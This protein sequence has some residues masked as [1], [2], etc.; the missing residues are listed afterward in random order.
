MAREEGGRRISALLPGGVDVTSMRSVSGRRAMAGAMRSM[1][2]VPIWSVGHENSEE[3]RVRAFA[4]RVDRADDV[5]PHVTIR[6][7]LANPNVGGRC[8]RKTKLDV[9][10]GVAD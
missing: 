10:P 3:S 9:L 8:R 1:F 7:R 5:S 6:A 2:G 4:C